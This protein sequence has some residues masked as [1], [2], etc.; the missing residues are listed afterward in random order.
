MRMEGRRGKC[1]S[2]LEL[3][4]GEE[5]PMCGKQWK[6]EVEKSET[7]S[8][9]SRVCAWRSEIWNASWFPVPV[10]KV[11]RALSRSDGVGSRVSRDMAGFRFL[12]VY[13]YINLKIFNRE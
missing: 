9:S 5:M 2:P 3:D 6:L 12:N 7:E 10:T 1:N 8:G 13:I 11:L 4:E